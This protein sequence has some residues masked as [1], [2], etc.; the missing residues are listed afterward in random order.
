MKDPIKQRGPGQPKKPYAETLQLMAVRQHPKWLKMFRE[1]SRG[2]PDS[3]AKQVY[4]GIELLMEKRN[5]IS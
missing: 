1:W 2:Q 3:Q 4:E 5:R